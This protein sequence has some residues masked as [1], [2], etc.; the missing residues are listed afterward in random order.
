MA[1]IEWVKQKLVNWALW[2]ARNEGGGLGFATR[3]VLLAEA[4]DTRYA[5]NII[6]VLEIDGEQTNVAVESL[7]LTRPRLYQTLQ[8]IYI[9]NTGIKGAARAQGIAVSTVSALL[10]AADHALSAW[11]GDKAERDKDKA[12]GFTS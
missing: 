5:G 9:E 10:E 2:K 1:R 12:R 8:L 7:K 3:S 6:P 4:S 11:F